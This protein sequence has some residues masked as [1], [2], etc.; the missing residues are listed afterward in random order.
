MVEKATVN[1]DP[2][3]ANYILK[4][5]TE[6]LSYTYLK[7]RLEIPC[8]KDTYYNRY[9]QFFGCLV[10]KENSSRKPQLLL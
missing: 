3:L 6:E 7:T 2:E 1:S 9:R 4:A 5:V 8:S 10:K